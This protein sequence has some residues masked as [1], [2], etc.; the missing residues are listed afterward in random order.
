[1]MEKKKCSPCASREIVKNVET[2]S[3]SSGRTIIEIVEREKPQA[4]LRI[5]DFILRMTNY[6]MQEMSNSNSIKNNNS[7]NKQKIL[8]K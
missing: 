5:S 8:E 1:M 3:H 4:L 2:P 6:K 7:K